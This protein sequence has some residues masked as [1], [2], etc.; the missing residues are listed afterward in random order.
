MVGWFVGCFVVGCVFAD[1]VSWLPSSG[2]FVLVSFVV[3]CSLLV[4]WLWVAWCWL[5]CCRLPVVLR[6]LVRYL[7]DCCWR[8]VRL[9][10]SWLFCSVFLS[11]L[12]LVVLLFD[13]LLVGVCG[14]TSVGLLFVDSLLV[15]GW[16]VSCFVDACLL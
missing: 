11:A 5:V 12:L 14:L 10:C 7:I 16:F 8:V 3:G 4:C 13:G 1:P 15:V 9:L 6:F 2:C